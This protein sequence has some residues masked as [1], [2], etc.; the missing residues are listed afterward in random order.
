MPLR[1]LA[2]LAR[3]FIA[4]ALARGDPQIDD[5]ASVLRM[6]H[7]G[8]GTEIANEDNLIHRPGHGDLPFPA[9]SIFAANSRPSLARFASLPAACSTGAGSCTCFVPERP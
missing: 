9:L 4:P 6:P 2:T 1:P 5:R 7:L 3:R 8:I